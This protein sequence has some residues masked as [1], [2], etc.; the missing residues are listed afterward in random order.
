MSIENSLEI[1]ARRNLESVRSEISSNDVMDDVLKMADGW[2]ELGLFMTGGCT[3][4]SGNF[5]KIGQGG[6]VVG[7]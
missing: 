1:F 4:V 7:R 5:A 2:R 6:K 3:N